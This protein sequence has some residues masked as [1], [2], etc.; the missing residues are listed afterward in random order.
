M[1]DSKKKIQAARWE[2]QM[3]FSLQRAN[4][5]LTEELELKT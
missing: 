2:K 3:V 4:I 5:L 1:A